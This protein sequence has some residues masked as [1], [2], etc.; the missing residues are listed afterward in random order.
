MISIKIPDL[1]I[2]QA[3]I[4][5]INNKTKPLQSLGRLEDLA[6]Q[7]GTVQQ[8]LSPQLSQAHILVF[9]ADHGIAR[10]G[11][12]AYPPEVTAQMVL[13][14]VQGGAAINVL[15]R[16]HGIALKVVDAG[17]NFTFAPDTP[18]YPAKIDMGTKSYLQQTAMTEEQL[19]ACMSE[20]A[21]IVR[22]VHQ[23]GCNVIGFGEMGIGNTSSASLLMHTLLRLP[24]E[25]CVGRGTG[26]N[27][28]QYQQK[29]SIL[30]Q[31]VNKHSLT[32]SD[33]RKA[34]QTFG[35]YE[36]AMICGGMLQ[37]ASLGI[38]VLVDGFI[39]SS[40]Y[41][42]AWKLQAAISHYAIFCHQSDEQGHRLLLE[43]LGA[44][45]LLQL[46]MRLGEGTGC[47]TAYP[48][49]Q[50][51]VAFLNEMASFESAGVSKS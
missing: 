11:V 17:V 14:F 41:L 30:Q 22:E 12:S 31:A 49:L 44:S 26:L 33:P 37:A 23:T 24:L 32:D 13:N 36:I 1:S 45:P 3:L 29:L 42:C 20:G 25:E 48:L 16:Q 40:A 39:A 2:Q 10:E 6:L 28:A 18:V 50:S 7:I 9:A 38:L 51:A 4:Q 19:E 34:L 8:S 46:D 35:G 15:T 21:K 5:K 47:A 43:K 27:D